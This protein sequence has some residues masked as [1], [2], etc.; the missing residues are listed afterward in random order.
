MTD[1][2]GHLTVARRQRHC[3]GAWAHDGV[4]PA[5]SRYV[6]V[7]LFPKHADHPGGDKPV[8]V[9]LCHVCAAHYLGVSWAATTT[10]AGASS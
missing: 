10:T 7:T 5:G 2:V 4:I 8:D 3:A 1:A 9:V 6:R